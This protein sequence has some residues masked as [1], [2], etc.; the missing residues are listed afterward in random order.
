[1]RLVFRELEKAFPEVLFLRVIA[2]G[3]YDSKEKGFYGTLYSTFNEEADPRGRAEDR[4]QAIKK[5]WISAARVRRA[6]CIV[7]RI[8]E[9]QDWGAQEMTWL[10][11][12]SNELEESNSLALHV[13]ASGSEEVA[14]RARV[15]ASQNRK[16]LIGR[17]MATIVPVCGLRS[18]EELQT[19][20]VGFDQADKYCYPP[21]T[22]ISYTEFFLPMAYVGGF[23]L[24]TQAT[25]L[26]RALCEFADG[27]HEFGMQRVSTSVKT[28]FT[29]MAQDQHCD[30]EKVLEHWR[31]AVQAAPNV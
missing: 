11:A 25:A 12:I 4:K 21:G 16:D 22:G 27:Q 13:I 17:F 18:A 31:T 2:T 24:A 3:R 30:S 1:M 6:N 20:L 26:W 10:K 15:L 7:L 8:D 29:L 28:F 5:A 9:I 14:Q 23:R 19:Y